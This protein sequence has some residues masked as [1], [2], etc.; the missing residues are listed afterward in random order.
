MG[1]IVGI[2]QGGT[3]TYAALMDRQGKLWSDYKCEGCYF[4]RDG[5]EAALAV[6]SKAVTNALKIAEV[7]IEEVEI[8]VAGVTG[9]DYEGDEAM[10]EEALQNIYPDIKI[11]VCNDC[12]IAYYSGSLNPIGAVIC[13]GT[14]INAALFAPDGRKFVMGDYLK[15]SLQGGAAISKR[16][17]EAVVEADLGAL[18]KTNLTNLF[19]EFSQEEK[20]YDL[21]R[22]FIT[23]EE[24][25]LEIISLVPQIIESAN[26]NDEVARNILDS[27]SKELCACFLA[28]LKRMNMLDLNCDIVL[29]GSVFK[30]PTNYLVQIMAKELL[31]TAKNIKIINANYE[32]IVG[33]CILGVISLVG[34]YDEKMNE[35]TINSAAKWGLLRSSPQAN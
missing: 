22:R 14:G 5:V 3:K 27:F 26:N 4:P 13:A 8:I 17:L 15:S 35:N 19:L 28:A 9:I 10:M 7:R 30:G 6:I 33:A 1:Y 23:D 32:P 21:L 18:A 24:F 31:T 12:E 29:A 2:D 34:N 16:A 25:S 11:V 20:V